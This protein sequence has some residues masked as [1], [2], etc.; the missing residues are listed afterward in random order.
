M[1]NRFGCSELELRRP[2]N[3]INIGPRSSREVHSAKLLVLIPNLPTNVGS[4]GVR[5]REIASSQAPICNP[6]TR[7]PRNPLH[8]QFRA[9]SS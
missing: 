9:C 1:C 5:N 2:K 7:N 8:E 6:P 4:E 3:G